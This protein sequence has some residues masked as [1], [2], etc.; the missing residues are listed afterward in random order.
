MEYLV[1]VISRSLKVTRLALLMKDEEGSYT[2]R[3]G[4]GVGEEILG[5]YKVNDGVIE[6]IKQKKEVF[7]KEEQQLAL[8]QAR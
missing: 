4:Y 5:R 2:V 6:W 1:D 7:V 8:P 3:W